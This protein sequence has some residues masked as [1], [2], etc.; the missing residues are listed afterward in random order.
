MLLTGVRC[1][2]TDV[3]R[4][5]DGHALDDGGALGVEDGEAQAGGLDRW[6][7][8]DAAVA[9]GSQA[10]ALLHQFVLQRLPLPVDFSLQRELPNPLA[11]AD[12]L[13]DHKAVAG[14]PLLDVKGIT[15][16]SPLPR[17]RGRG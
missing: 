4:Q 13:L 12:I 5:I 1:I 17:E 9:D 7:A 10:V 11:V 15:D 2:L 8:D 6:E 3:G 16:Y 14:S